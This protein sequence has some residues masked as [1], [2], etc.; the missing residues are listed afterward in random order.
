MVLLKFNGPVVTLVLHGATETVGERAGESVWGEMVSERGGE[1]V[2][3]GVGERA[4]RRKERGG[5][6]VNTHTI[7]PPPPCQSP[8]TSLRATSLHACCEAMRETVGE[9]A[10]ER[11]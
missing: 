11:V 10:G 6:I 1:R 9:R 3:K 7:S 8:R 5:W 4:W 2:R